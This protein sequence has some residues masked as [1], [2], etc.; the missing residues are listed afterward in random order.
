M[1]DVWEAAHLGVKSALC[2]LFLPVP[3]MTGTWGPTPRC[4]T[5]QATQEEVPQ[6]LVGKQH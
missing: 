4:R 6:F 5:S 3:A 2:G 1:G